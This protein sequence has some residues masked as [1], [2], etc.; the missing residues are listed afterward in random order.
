MG[1]GFRPKC[2]VFLGQVQPK[3]GK[4]VNPNI[5]SDANLLTRDDCENWAYNI[6]ICQVQSMQIIGLK[7]KFPIGSNDSAIGENFCV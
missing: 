1:T 3:V 4:K 5:Y 2:I 7:S 6:K